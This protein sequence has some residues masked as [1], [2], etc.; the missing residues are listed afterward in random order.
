ML[1]SEV[2]ARPA[3]GDMALPELICI[4]PRIKLG[5]LSGVAAQGRTPQFSHILY[6][7]YCD[8]GLCSKLCVATCVSLFAQADP[9]RAKC[10]VLL[11][12]SN[13]L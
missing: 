10:L 5:R 8:A 3:M 11:G 12:L 6:S 2:V 9:I 7:V 1:S 13:V 4:V